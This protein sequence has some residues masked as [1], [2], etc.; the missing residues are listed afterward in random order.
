MMETLIKARQFETLL[1]AKQE[2]VSQGSTEKEFDSFLT[3]FQEF[4]KHMEAIENKPSKERLH[5]RPYQV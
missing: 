2:F 3:T 5:G 4:E 1:K